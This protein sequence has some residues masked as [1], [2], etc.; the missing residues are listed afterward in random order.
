MSAVR[1]VHP[2]FA[3]RYDLAQPTFVCLDGSA[4]ISAK[5]IN[6]DYCDCRDGSDEPGTS[7]CFNAHF[8]CVGVNPK[9]PKLY[10]FVQLPTSRIND[11][12]CDSQCCDGTDEYDGR[13]VCPV[14][15]SSDSVNGTYKIFSAFSDREMS[16][17]SEYWPVLLLVC[18]VYTVHA[19]AGSRRRRR[20]SGMRIPAVHAE[21]TDAFST[22]R[23]KLKPH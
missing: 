2:A 23:R 4:K 8:F 13:V 1:G 11:G 17:K 14:T 5:S 18:L 20:A 7:A 22:F 6:D 21:L 10:S 16:A 19:W 3:Y 15:C 9:N 12:I